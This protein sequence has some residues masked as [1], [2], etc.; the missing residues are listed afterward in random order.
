MPDD[1]LLDA[2]A[3][4]DL[5]TPE[6]LEAAVGRLLADGRARDGLARFSNQLVKLYD[7]DQVSRD[8][9]RFPDW[10]ALREAM[11]EETRRLLAD[12]MWTDGRG[13]LDLL[14][15]KHTFV[16]A[17]LAKHYGL[18]APTSTST[19]GWG[20]VDLGQ[21]PRRRGYLTQGSFL[22]QTAATEIVAPIVRGAFIREVFLC[23]APPLPEE[24]IP[25]PPESTQ[26]K[27]VRE[28]LAEHRA[29]ACA[30]CHALL[31]PIGFGLER[32]D[33]NGVYRDKDPDGRPLTGAGRLEG[34]PEPD[35][36][37]PFELASRLVS[38]PEAKTCLATN[39]FRFTFG[40]DEAPA[41][42]CTLS[43]LEQALVDTKLDLRAAL[44][45]LVRSDA[46]RSLGGMP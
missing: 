29:G 16:N 40:R 41:D 6:G 26:G 2:A 43:V 44:T 31:D 21:D 13:F 30:G 7:L 32:Y 4:G 20:R 23:N 12:V 27:S 10:P 3:R 25:P 5:D 34:A 46:F 39:L 35:F 33:A 22:V 28:I 11:G 19:A 14:T 1:A 8:P 45:R 17:A 42:A 38:L 9:Q 37:G 24:S 36:V 15:A 18:T